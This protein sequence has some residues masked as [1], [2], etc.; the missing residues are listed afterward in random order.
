MTI[1]S[2]HA[3][4]GGGFGRNSAIRRKISWNICGWTSPTQM[5][6][7]PPNRVNFKS[8]CLVRGALIDGYSI[9]AAMTASI[10]GPKQNK[11]HLRPRASRAN[12]RV[13]PIVAVPGSHFFHPEEEP[14]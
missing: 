4:A 9:A 3:G 10:G 12:G 5:F 14:K 13:K 1:D 2:S 11:R 8:G 7:C 6:G